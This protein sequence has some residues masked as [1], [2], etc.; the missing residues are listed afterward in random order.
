MGDQFVAQ[1]ISSTIDLIKID[2]DGFDYEV[3]VGL[4]QTIESHQ[5][6]VQFEVSHWWLEMGYTLTQAIRFFSSR[7]YEC[8]V[9]TNSGLL[10]IGA[11]A[12]DYLFITAN[13]VA[14]PKNKLDKFK[15]Q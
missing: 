7:N 13:I 3:I 14:I 10:N 8:R 6:I 2:T 5:P 12:P 1:N 9:L 15:I 4:S 11:I